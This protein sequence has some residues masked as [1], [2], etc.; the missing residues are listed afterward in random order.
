MRS[1][2]NTW[3]ESIYG[4]RAHNWAEYLKEMMFIQ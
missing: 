4:I 3:R 2:V 1:G